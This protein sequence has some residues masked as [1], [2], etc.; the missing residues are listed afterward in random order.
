[1]LTR[2][3]SPQH[4]ELASEVVR[5]TRR[6]AKRYKR[7]R[8]SWGDL[9]VDA[10]SWALGIGVSLTVAASFVLAL[11]NEIAQRASTANSII[12]AQWLVLPEAVLWTSVTFAVLLVIGNLARKLGPM[13][14]NGAES[15]W[16]LTLPVDR[17]PMV[18]PPFARKVALTAAGSGVIYLPF[19]MVTAVDR[20]PMEHVFA[21]LTFGAAGA[22]AVAMA[23]IQQLALLGPRLGKAIAT[24]ALLTCSVLPAMP[25]SPWPAALVGVAAVA[26]FAVV[27]PRAGHVKGDEL[28]RGGAV[29]GHAGAS[30]FMMDSNEV[31]RAL[32]GNRRRVDGGRA[33]SFYAQ[34][35]RGPLWAL[36][37][38]DV[39]AFL[40]LNPPLTPPILWL[41]ACNA[42][43]LVEGGLPEFAQL[44]VIVIAGCATASGLGS[45]ARKTALVPEL[46]ALLPLHPAL[47]RTSRTLMPCLAM[48]AWM[49]VLSGLLV[50]LGAANPWLIGVGA[51]AGVG[52]GAGTLRAATRTP[53]D[54]TAPPV[55]TPFG[56]VPRAQLGSLMRGLDVTV[57]AMVPL[58]LALYLGYVPASLVII[59]AV[60]SAGIFLVVVLTRPKRI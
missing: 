13:T 2:E 37:R 45:V 35:A 51:L 4:R 54:W 55:E 50:L 15:T 10:Y 26:L 7:S 41:A 8:T 9:F 47:V 16:W 20:A 14:V 59:Q 29:A 46:D 5:F 17:R 19:S 21:S 39:V 60:L 12:R 22:I 57:L 56:P 42:I 18:L 11:R 36:I 32:G 53:P 31:L 44:A 40:R 48:A 49:A 58:L 30:L 33:A 6:S 25:S 24:A 27:A 38:A 28:V 3:F 52:M 23:G 1:M 43:L 34:P